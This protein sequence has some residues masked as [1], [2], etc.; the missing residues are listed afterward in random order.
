MSGQAYVLTGSALKMLQHIVLRKTNLERWA[1]AGHSGKHHH[2][3]VT[4]SAL[5]RHPTYH[6]CPWISSWLY[7]YSNNLHPVQIHSLHLIWIAPLF[8][9]VWLDL[10]QVHHGVYGLIKFASIYCALVGQKGELH[11]CGSPQVLWVDV[12]I[13][14]LTSM[15]WFPMA[16]TVCLLLML[17]SDLESTWPWYFLLIICVR[18]NCKCYDNFSFQLQVLFCFVFCFKW[19]GW[20]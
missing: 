2:V 10:W 8:S 18:S 7:S 13:D 5:L 20:P 15:L 17:Q 14:E 16:F 4:P 3:E 19:V 1:A 11:P 12:Q 9:I 6:A